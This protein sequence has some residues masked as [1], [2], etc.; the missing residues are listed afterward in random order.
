MSKRKHGADVSAVMRGTSGCSIGD[1]DAVAQHQRAIRVRSHTLGVMFDNDHRSTAIREAAQVVEDVIAEA[2]GEG[3]ERLVEQG[4]QGSGAQASRQREQPLFPTTQ[5][6]RGGGLETPQAERVQRP[7]DG[8]RRRST[9]SSEPSE[10]EVL[11]DGEGGEKVSFL[12]DEGNTAGGNP[13]RSP[14]ID[15]LASEAYLARHR[16]DQAGERLEKCRLARTVGALEEDELPS[17]ELEVDATEHRLSASA[18]PE[19]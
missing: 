19:M 4:H 7:R 1:Q 11:A 16:S 14:P 10:G 5:Q 13:V 12:V 3:G 6:P 2:V 15:T 17:A 18:R 9:S 8:V